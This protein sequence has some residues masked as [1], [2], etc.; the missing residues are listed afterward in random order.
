MRSL[1][2]DENANPINMYCVDCRIEG[3]PW[4]DCIA[5]VVCDMTTRCMEHFDA[6]VIR[7]NL[8]KHEH[9]R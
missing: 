9:Q 3:K 1:R 4:E 5:V 2:V 6:F 7:N 8:T